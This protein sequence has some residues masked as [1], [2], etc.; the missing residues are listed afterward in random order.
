M[1]REIEQRIARR[2]AGIRLAFRGVVGLVNANGP[3]QL[4]QGDA[5]AGENGRDYELFQDYGYTSNPPSGTMK[6]VLPIGGKTSHGIIVATENARYRIKGLKSGEV[7][8]YTD[9]G[10]SIILKRGRLID[11]TTDT[12]RINAK[13]MEVNAATKIDFK[14]PMVNCSEQVTVQHRINGNGGMAIENTNGTGAA[15]TIE[16]AINQTG[17]GFSTD[18]DVTIQGR[19]QL[20]HKHTETGSITD[21]QQ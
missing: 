8:I 19:S 17:G 7:A 13:V 21:E 2:L 6:I 15:A 18:T 5:L 20:H 9:E 1:I 3:V 16:G 14:T 4:V 10:D 12:L 11:V